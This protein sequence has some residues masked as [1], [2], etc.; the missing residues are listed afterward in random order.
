MKFF[1]AFLCALFLAAAA[2]V[3]GQSSSSPDD[4]FAQVGNALA[5]SS[6]PAASPSA[7]APIE[8]PS[9]IP[10]NILP[11]PNA[12]PKVPA[13]AGL[14]ELNAFF[15]QTSLGKAADDFRLHLQMAELEVQIRNDQDLHAMRATALRARTDLEKRHLL[16][17]YYHLYFDK[18]RALA[19]APDIKAY[20]NTREASD[21]LTL[22]QPRVR[23]QTDT[24]IA[25]TLAQAIAGAS[26][27]PALPTP[28]QAPAN[29]ALRKH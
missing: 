3:W 25:A 12:L 13:T 21:E 29:R 15:K 27:P 22:L 5:S 23:H 14:D 10:S 11:P 20:L 2:I 1:L 7:T 9:L 28:V 19:T 8:P 24:V 4:P 16:R 26:V 17:A 18:L 6:V